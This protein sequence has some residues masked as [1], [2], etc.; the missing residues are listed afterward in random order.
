MRHKIK[1]V[2]QTLNGVTEDMNR[3]ALMS[4]ILEEVTQRLPELLHLPTMVYPLFMVTYGLD[5]T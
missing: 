3:D 5:F 2:V 1:Y 4:S